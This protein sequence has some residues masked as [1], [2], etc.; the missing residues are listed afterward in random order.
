MKEVRVVS[1]SEALGYSIGQMVSAPGFTLLCEACIIHYIF[2]TSGSTLSVD[3]KS[4]FHHFLGENPIMILVAST[5]IFIFL[6]SYLCTF[7]IINWLCCIA[8]ISAWLFFW[9]PNGGLNDSNFLWFVIPGGFGALII[10]LSHAS[11]NDPGRQ[12][13]DAQSD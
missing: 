11:F 7:K 9:L 4:V 3:Y 1:D 8:S 5:F 2:W 12:P 6:Y 10:L 13:V